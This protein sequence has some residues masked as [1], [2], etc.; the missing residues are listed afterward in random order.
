M[1]NVYAAILY[2]NLK[3]AFGLIRQ[4]LRSCNFSDMQKFLEIEDKFLLNKIEASISQ[5]EISPFLSQVHVVRQKSK[6]T[7]VRKITLLPHII[8]IIVQF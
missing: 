7:F 1:A 3:I 5:A 6:S 8:I 4:N 2:S